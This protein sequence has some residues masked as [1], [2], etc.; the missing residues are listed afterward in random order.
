M[1]IAE[2]LSLMLAFGMFIATMLN[3]V[4]TIVKLFFD[5]KK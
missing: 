5:N 1:S 3:L 2:T 4:I